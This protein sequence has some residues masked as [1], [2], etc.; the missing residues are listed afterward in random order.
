LVDTFETLDEASER[1][2]DDQRRR[3][4]APEFKREEVALLNT[5]A[6]L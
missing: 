2:Y 6:D 5:A 1:C 3:E 4:L